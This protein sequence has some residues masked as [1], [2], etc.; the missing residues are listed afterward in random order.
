LNCE[1]RN[2]EKFDLLLS[3][4]KKKKEK[5]KPY[6]LGPLVQLASVEFLF[7]IQMVDRVQEINFT[8]RHSPPVLCFFLSSAGNFSGYVF[9][10]SYWAV[11]F[12]LD[13]T[14]CL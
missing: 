14:H 4:D 7:K 13:G 1:T 2:V 5:D 10:F 9:G 12:S 3:S 8:G 11:K 6:L